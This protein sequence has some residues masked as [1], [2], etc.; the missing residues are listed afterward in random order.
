M[1]EIPEDPY[2]FDD[3]AR[4]AFMKAYALT[5]RIAAA[6]KAAGISLTYAYQ[7]RKID[8]ELDAE[9]TAAYDVYR[10]SIEAEIHRRAITGVT[11]KRFH[12]GSP[13]QDFELDDEGQPIVDDNG[14]IVLHHAI[15][16]KYSDTLLLAHA[17]RHIPEYN[18]KRNVD[19]NVTGLEGLLAE[20]SDTSTDLP[21][22][23][24]KL[25]DE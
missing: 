5:G 21:S 20:I 10:S 23:D 3:R 12:Q 1:D 19:M 6:C 14:E 7:R 9:M 18:E 2:K 16:R 25:D 24:E 11:E 13:I 22:V 17:R 15:I 4:K 8:E